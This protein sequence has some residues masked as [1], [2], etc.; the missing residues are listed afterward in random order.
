MITRDFW[1][2]LKITFY[3]SADLS[4]ALFLVLAVGTIT[5]EGNE[6]MIWKS[7]FK[8]AV[9]F[10][11]AVKRWW[12]VWKKRSKYIFKP[13]VPITKP[14]IVKKLRKT[15]ALCDMAHASISCFNHFRSQFWQKVIANDKN[16][17]KRVHFIC[18]SPATTLSTFFSRSKF[19][20]VEFLLKS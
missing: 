16:F 10:Q 1:I 5:R 12:P 8:M 18:L 20:D 6:V 3:T 7:R 9:L 11:K 19:S 15:L 2:I 14:R 17:R 4:L 13:P